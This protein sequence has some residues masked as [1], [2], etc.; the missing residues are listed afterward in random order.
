M[1]AIPISYANQIIMVK[2]VYTYDCNSYFFGEQVNLYLDKTH[3]VM[4]S[5]STMAPEKFAVN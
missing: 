4:W 5:A 1:A 2:S 3:C